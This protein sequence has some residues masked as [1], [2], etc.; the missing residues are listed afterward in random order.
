[1]P[2]DD[3]EQSEQTWGRWFLKFSV[4][5]AIGGAVF[6]NLLLPESSLVVQLLVGTP[7]VLTLAIA[8]ICIF[9]P[10]HRRSLLTLWR[11]LRCFAPGYEV[12][13]A[14]RHLG[15]PGEVSADEGFELWSDTPELDP[16]AVDQT[17]ID[18]QRL[19]EALVGTT[20]APKTSVRIFAFRDHE[21]FEKQLRH[22]S[23]TP[24]MTGCYMGKP[25]PTIYL[26]WGQV[27]VDADAWRG[28]LAHEYTHFLT[29]VYLGFT[30]NPWLHE[31][32]ASHIQA[33]IDPLLRECDREAQCT[34]LILSARRNNEF[35]S[36]D[37]LKSYG[38]RQL[39][40]SGAFSGHWDPLAIRR[41]DRFYNQSMLLVR[42]LAT[43]HGP[44]LQRYLKNLA[45]AERRYP[46]NLDR[47]FPQSFSE[48]LEQALRC[49]KDQPEVSGIPSR[50]ARRQTD[51]C[52]QILARADLPPRLYVR[53][54]GLLGLL[55]SPESLAILSEMCANNNPLIAELASLELE[56]L[57]GNETIPKSKAV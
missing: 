18:T 43:E 29:E 20:I 47:A 35:F 11:Y 24:N 42:H 50:T 27:R 14:D 34:R 32:I 23:N 19:F 15:R 10:E 44:C 4:L 16:N 26:C 51:H 31:G 39:L 36:A 54:I 1:M 5:L 49:P 2:Q 52:R 57:T 46:P 6:G 38:Y 53:A 40:A 33:C 37:D 56:E 7:T 41:M 48:L 13:L 25:R 30:P 21:A 17:L 3:K 8:A 55:A 12:R 45:E 28:I 9:L 22:L